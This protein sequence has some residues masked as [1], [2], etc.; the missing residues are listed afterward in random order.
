M[1]TKTLNAH[2]AG[3]A[4][5]FDTNQTTFTLDKQTFTDG[6][7]ITIAGKEYTIGIAGAGTAGTAVSSNTNVTVT[8]TYNGTANETLTYK[9]ATGGGTAGWYSGTNATTTP[10]VV[11]AGGT[12]NGVTISGTATANDTITLTAGTAGTAPAGKITQ[13]DA[14]DKI[15]DELKKA[16]SIG[17][18]TEANVTNNNDGTF[19]ITK[20]S[21]NIKDALS[22]NLHVGADADTT[23]KISVKIDSMSSAGLGIKGIKADTEQDATYAID[24]IADAISKY[25]SSVHHSV[26]F[27][28]V[29]STQS[30][31]LT[32]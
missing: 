24:A 12:Y 2:D 6:D 30:T 15:A 10:D 17:A 26:R 14:F 22:F 20:G 13:N 9:D 8:G 3:I 7:K 11:A 1:P 19:T 28:T 21:V 29:L 25:L 31:T 4:G 5:K 18:D 23:N 16:S 27:R 32:T